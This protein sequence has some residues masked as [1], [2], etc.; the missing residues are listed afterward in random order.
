MVCPPARSAHVLPRFFDYIETMF[1]GIV[2]VVLFISPAGAIGRSVRPAKTAVGTISKVPAGLAAPQ[3]GLSAGSLL[4]A[5]NIPEIFAVDPLA[6]PEAIGKLHSNAEL[7]DND[8]LFIRTAI[9]TAGERARSMHLAKEKLERDEGLPDKEREKE[10]TLA[11]EEG[12]K[13]VLFLM[14]TALLAQREGSDMR[15]SA[16]DQLRALYQSFGQGFPDAL[17]AYKKADNP[18]GLNNQSTR[19]FLLDGIMDYI[20][21]QEVL[22][23]AAPGPS[24]NPN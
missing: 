1:R 7:N 8:R 4:P 12:K 19:D 21:G 17:T 5:I 9:E 24:E 16:I 20:K 15:R 23:A 6:L 14:R 10:M 11:R 3:L 18:R 13:D 22:A 2:I